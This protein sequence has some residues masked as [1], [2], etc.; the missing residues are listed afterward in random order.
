[1]PSPEIL[2]SRRFD[3]QAN[4]AK[5]SQLGFVPEGLFMR[6]APGSELLP[7]GERQLFI[8]QFEK[9]V[10]F[11]QL[12]FLLISRSC[13]IRNVDLVWAERGPS[14]RVGLR[15]LGITEALASPNSTLLDLCEQNPHPSFCNI[16]NGYGLHES[17]TC[18]RSDK[19]AEE[20]VRQTGKAQIYRCHFGLVD[21]A[22]PV[23]VGNQHIATL[24][25]GQ[26]LR[27]LPSREEFMQITR[28]VE[29]FPHI[30]CEQLQAAYWQVP[31]VSADNIRNITEILE[32]FAEYIANSWQRMAEAVK[33]RRRK[34]RE[35]Q[36]AR[37]EFAFHALEG[38]EALSVSPDAMRGL[39][40]DIGF[41]HPPNRVLAVRLEA[42]ERSPDQPSPSV[43]VSQAEA[44]QA[45]EDVCEKLDNIVAV[46]LH[47]TGICLFIYDD[48]DS[49]AGDAQFYV[50]RLTTHIVH[51]VRDRFDV[52]VRV[53]VGGVVKEWRDLAQSYREAHLALAGSPAAVASYMQPTGSFQKL[54]R[55]SDRICRLVK[56]KR[57]TEAKEAAVILPVEV[58][59]RIGV[60]LNGLAAARAFFTSALESLDLTV[61]DLGCDPSTV[62]DVC[63]TAISE[64]RRSSDA[65]QLHEIWVRSAARLIEEVRWLYSGKRSK[66]AQR[67]CM[68]V[69]QLL[70]RCAS[71]E[72]FSISEIAA[73]LGVSA[74]HMS[75]TFRRATGDTYE[76][77]LMVKRIELAKRLLLDPLHNVSE[78]ALRCGFSDPS[79]FARVFRRIA[80][81]SPS[82]YCH[83]PLRPPPEGGNPEAP[84]DRA[85]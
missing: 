38:P 14:G 72:K 41:S 25:T 76:H 30:Q 56:E 84:L 77:Y 64:L 24:F 68:I 67:A 83:N 55:N 42:E 31:V 58:S 71:P 66:I 70:E 32:A 2:G 65:V 5:I 50:H 63:S 57:F 35:L 11:F 6:S 15:H 79:Y 52:R 16:I 10:G 75:R 60:S 46:H 62:A 18:G 74:S 12:F 49:T 28:D 3:C 43:D 59:R 40:R 36:I 1:M 51:A 82:E 78:V 13:P 34:D 48:S 33:E 73:A 19:A 21:I 54:S 45:I 9:D 29:S 37:K 47:K 44:L 4:G 61:R 27:D 85:G 39:M 81:C 7:P 23:I 53:G 8:E 80:G 22:V 20:L 26:V 17:E 69:D